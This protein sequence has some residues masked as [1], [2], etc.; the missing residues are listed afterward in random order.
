MSAGFGG[1]TDQDIK[2]GFSKYASSSLMLFL[3]PRQD[4]EFFYW[5]SGDAQE[6]ERKR[7]LF[8]LSTQ[9]QPNFFSTTECWLP[10]LR[11]TPSQVKRDQS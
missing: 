8:A 5:G 2:D 6:S 1:L 9:N 3:W 11:S 4:L 10:R 7:R